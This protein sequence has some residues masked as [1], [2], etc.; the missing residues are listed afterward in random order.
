M[1]D[2]YQQQQTVY[3]VTQHQ[4]D[5]DYNKSSYFQDNNGPSTSKILAVVTL[6]PLGG[7]LVALA[8]L[9]FT[10]TL[11]GLAITTPLFLLFSPILVPAALVIGLSVA[12]FLTSGAFGITGLSSLSWIANYLRRTGPYA[13]RQFELGKRQAQDAAGQ[14]GQ[15]TKEVGQKIQNKSQEGG[16]A[17]ATHESGRDRDQESGKTVEVQVAKK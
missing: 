1:A 4:T 17:A 12:G 9:S 6:L 3:R 16:R 10:A 13:S 14:L 7:T 5:D 8:G 11:I 15:R 2:Q